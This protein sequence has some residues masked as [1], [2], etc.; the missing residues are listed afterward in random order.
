MHPYEEDFVLEGAQ[1]SRTFAVD[2]DNGVRAVK[3][4]LW[5]REQS[6]LEAK[7]SSELIGDVFEDPEAYLV[8]TQS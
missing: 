2:S 6:K 8:R 5:Q 1:I 7:L 4:E 3:S